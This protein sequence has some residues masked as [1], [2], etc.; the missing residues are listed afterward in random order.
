MKIKST[1]KNET[2]KKPFTTVNEALR[3]RDPATRRDFTEK[4]DNRA[5]DDI[6]SEYKRK[7][8]SREQPI[9]VM[10]RN[11][12]LIDNISR[13]VS[14]GEINAQELQGL[15]IKEEEAK[16]YVT[17]IQDIDEKLK[18]AKTYSKGFIPNFAQNSER[19]YSVLDG[20]SLVIDKDY[21]DKK[22]QGK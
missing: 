15:G 5:F 8:G 9:Y 3:F 11:S 6:S 7:E 1:Y 20:D 22:L 21:P 17:E 10:E 2:A 14:A 13:G 12:T 18:K 19:G 4:K 16:R